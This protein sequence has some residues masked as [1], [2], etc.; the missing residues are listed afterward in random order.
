MSSY[1][2]HGDWPKCSYIS[3]N[4]LYLSSLINEF[5]EKVYNLTRIGNAQNFFLDP[6]L[7]LIDK[8]IEKIM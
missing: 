8:P 2:Y 7:L 3:S 1:F 5:Y 6:K 4:G